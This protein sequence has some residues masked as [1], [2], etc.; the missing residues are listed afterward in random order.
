MKL[1]LGL[2][3]LAAQN[4]A[5]LS[6]I[7]TAINPREVERIDT[8]ENVD[9]LLSPEKGK[10]WTRSPWGCSKKGWCWKQCANGGQWCWVALDQGNGPWKSCQVAEDCNPANDLKSD[11][12]QGGCK[13]CGCSC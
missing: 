8:V 6:A 9:V 5:V 13:A 1:N 2:L 10:C 7:T 11:C 12:G 4:T 3:L